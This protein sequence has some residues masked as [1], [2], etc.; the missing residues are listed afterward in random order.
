MIKVET[1]DGKIAVQCGKATGADLICEASA[2]VVSVIGTAIKKCKSKERK[3]ALAKEVFTHIT[4]MSATIVEKEH[5]IS[6]WPDDDD[7]ADDEEETIIA[8][9]IPADSDTAKK[10]LELLGI[11]PDEAN[12]IDD[13]ETEDDIPKFLF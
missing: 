11:D 1:I 6:V 8:K 4:G 13:D 2:V 12:S 5:G 3:E 9:A 7:E 10:L